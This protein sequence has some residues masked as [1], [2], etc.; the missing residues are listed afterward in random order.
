MKAKIITVFSVIAVL[1][2]ALFGTVY[3]EGKNFFLTI[4]LCAIAGCVP[5]F[6]TFENQ[7]HSTRYLTLV[8]VMTAISVAGRFLFAPIPFFKPVSAVVIITGVCLGSH[9]GFV[10]GAMSA[11]VSN[12]YFGQGPWTPFQMLSWGLIGFFA[13]LLSKQLENNK[14]LLSLYGAFSGLF[15]SV[16]MDSYSVIFMEGSF[17]IKR[18]CA[19]FVTSIPVTLCYVVSNVVFLLLIGKAVFYSLK[20]IVKKYGIVEG[21]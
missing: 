21:G 7:K 2:I 4:F 15:Y 17:N 12:F 1:V 14:I 6:V 10:T 5:F 8:A 11:L 20:R 9:G 18:F 19:F 16:L 3:N 13:G